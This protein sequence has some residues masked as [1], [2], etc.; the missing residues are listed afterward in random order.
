MIYDFFVPEL[1]DIDA[2]DFWCPQN[3]ATCHT[4]NAAITD[5]LRETFDIASSKILLYNFDEIFFVG[6]S[7]MQSPRRLTQ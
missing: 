1:E 5:L 2:N 6:L 3:G 4:A 7:T